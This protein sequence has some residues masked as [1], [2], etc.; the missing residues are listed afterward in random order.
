[1]ASS[2]PVSKLATDARGSCSKGSVG[3]L[4]TQEVGQCGIIEAAC[5]LLDDELAGDEVAGSLC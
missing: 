1:M 2:E 3:V 4:S 5:D